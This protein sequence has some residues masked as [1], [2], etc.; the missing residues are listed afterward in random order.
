MSL[1]LQ[2]TAEAFALDPSPRHR[3]AVAEAALPLV[4]SMVKRVPL[5][6]HPL[7]SYGDL[8]NAGMLGM[9]Q[10]LDSYDPAHG[11]PFAS[12]A[13]G[14]IRGALVDFLRTIDTLSRGRRR[15]VA[16]VLRVTDE[17]EQEHG[18]AVHDGIVAERLGVEIEDVHRLRSDAQQRFSLA[19][20]DQG[21]SDDHASP[22]DTLAHPTAEAA[23]DAIEQRSLFDHVCALIEQLPQREREMVALYYFEN[24]TLRQIAEQYDLTEARISQILS[25]T[26]RGLRARLETT[27]QAA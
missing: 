17:L 9:L 13:Y 11:T 24:L 3:R 20:H 23:F 26:L 10:A 22:I 19:L 12:F 1:D 25:K 18:G 27:Q 6:D 15:K 4:R 5:P 21:G 16:E 14:R 7:A 2:T 8:E